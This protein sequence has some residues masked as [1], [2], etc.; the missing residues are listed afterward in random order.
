[1]IRKFTFL[2]VVSVFAILNVSPSFGQLDFEVTEGVIQEE[3]EA[4]PWKGS[5]AAGLNGKSGNSQNLD[6]N[7]TLN[8]A[9]ETDLAKT[10]LLATYFYASNNIA[11]VT[12]RVFA[13]A[14]QERKLQNDRM[15]LF[16]Q[17]GYEWDRFK[18]FD[19]RLALHSGL[20]YELIKEEGHKLDLR[21][22]A[23][24]SNEVGGAGAGWIPELQF[25]A[26]WDRQLTE[27]LRAYVNLD[28]FPNL[29][30]FGDFRLN[31][32]AGLECVLDAEKNINFRVF[33]LNR[34]DSTPPPGN[35]ANDIDYGMAVVVGF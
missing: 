29:D 30:D 6:I 14:R 12:D 35:V 21:M 26:D 23:G 20:A 19:Y 2:L 4:N 17:L 3:V 8:L 33:T 27:T 32:N 16:F 9:R 10:T 28:Y 15:S 7:A 31:T 25:G 11:T 22:G 13:Q 1:M 34:Y 5:V 24:A 18:D